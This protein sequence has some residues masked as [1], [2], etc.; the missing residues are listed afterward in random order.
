MP[1]GEVRDTDIADLAGAHELVEG[2]E[3]LFGRSEGVETVELE[4]VDVVGAEP[5]QRTVD[6]LEQ[7]LP[8]GAD[9]VGPITEAEGRLGRDQHLVA[10]AL[11]GF[12]EH[13]LGFAERIDIRGV[14]H[15]HAGFETDVQKAPRLGRVG[16]APRGKAADAALGAANITVNKNAVPND[17]RSPFVTSGIRIGSP[18]VTRRGLKEAE[19]LELAGWIADILDD[20]E[21]EETNK[22]VRAKVIELCTRFPVYPKSA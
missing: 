1:T 3:H 2:G 5:A 13:A 16:R 14:E 4:Q 11:D 19:C 15:R 7:M 21:N 18:A 17:P 10:A 8:R 9:V 6:G 20:I 12:P 22:A